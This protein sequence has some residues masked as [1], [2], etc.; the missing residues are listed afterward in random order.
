[1]PEVNVSFYQSLKLIWDADNEDHLWTVMSISQLSS[2]KEEEQIETCHELY[3]S[4]QTPIAWHR[5]LWELAV[6]LP[7]VHCLHFP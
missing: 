1:M 3:D 2:S 6:C 5:L 4:L 7:M